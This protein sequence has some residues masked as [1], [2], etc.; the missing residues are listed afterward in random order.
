MLLGLAL[1]SAAG[2]NTPDAFACSNSAQCA[3]PDVDG[4]CEGSGFCSFPDPDC[5]SGRRYGGLSG[6]LSNACV[7]DPEQGTDVTS[8]NA[9]SSEVTSS[10]ATSSP[11]EATSD[12]ASSSSGD[13]LAITSGPQTSTTDTGDMT[14]AAS[15]SSSSTSDSSS[16]G[17]VA[18]PDGLIGWWRLNDDPNDGVLDSSGNANHGTCFGPCPEPSD[19]GYYAFDGTQI[20]EIPGG[21]FGGDTFTIAVWTRPDVSDPEPD[22]IVFTKPVGAGVWN[23]WGIHY[24]SGFNRL[25]FVIGNPE[26]NQQVVLL[27]PAAGWHHYAGRFDGSEAT[28]FVDGEELE[29]ISVPEGFFGVDGSDVYI[30]GDQDNDT[31]PDPRFVGELDDVRYYD[32]LLTNDEIAELAAMP[33]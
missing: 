26:S 19:E 27:D 29:T 17:G 33:L 21:Q 15:E 4:P 11:G 30:G 12:A 18:V 8:G 2:C 7:D 16:S 28:L 1:S 3:T 23:S 22:P 32:R 14:T 13:T 10:P 6:A 25:E 31:P 5:P 24:N 20:I 9:T